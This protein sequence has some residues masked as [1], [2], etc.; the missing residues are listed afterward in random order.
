M[1][2]D[3]WGSGD[4]RRQAGRDAV[5]RRPVFGRQRD[6]ASLERPL[7]KMMDLPEQEILVERAR[8]DDAARPELRQRLLR[9]G[10]IADGAD[11]ELLLAVRMRREEGGERVVSEVFE[12]H[13][14]AR[15]VFT[16][17]DRHVDAA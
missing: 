1:N 6:R 2:E 15:R 16:V 14:P 7:A 9:L 5:E 10:E 17:D 8:R 3:A 12:Q 4:A 13:P 11:V